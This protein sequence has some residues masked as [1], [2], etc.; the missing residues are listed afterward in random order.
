ME[1]IYKDIA[2][3]R[4]TIAKDR[5]TLK[6]PTASKVSNEEGLINF[7]NKI[8]EEVG[9]VEYTIRGV[10]LFDAKYKP[11]IEMYSGTATNGIPRKFFKSFKGE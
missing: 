5:S 3:P 8:I 7:A 6:I 10:F 11:F 2:A 1:I 9:A 4:L